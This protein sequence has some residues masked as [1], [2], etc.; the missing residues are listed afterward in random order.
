[1]A[2][3]SVTR[4]RNNFTAFLKKYS[5]STPSA[6]A[7]KSLGLN[8]T[9]QY[10]F[11]PKGADLN[12]ENINL[13]KNEFL[14]QDFESAVTGNGSISSPD[15]NSNGELPKFWCIQDGHRLLYKQGSGPFYQQPY[16]EVFAS[17]LLDKLGYP[18]VP[19]TLAMIQNTPYSVCETFVIPD[20]EFIPANDILM[21]RKKTNS[22]SNY[23]HFFKCLEIL[24]IGV[25]KDDINNMIVFDKI[26]NNID[27]HYGN[28]GYIRN[29]ETLDFIEF[30][31]VFDNGNSLWYDT[32]DQEIMVREQPAKPFRDTQDKQLKLVDGTSL[33]I[34]NISQAFIEKTVYD[35]FSPALEA[36][37]V[38]ENS[39][40]GIIKCI[41]YNI[42]G[43]KSLQNSNGII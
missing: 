33:P 36:E 34:T 23:Q 29:P 9:D 22:D 1:M 11:K 31:P 43:V 39:L 25:T 8:L 14:K 2:Y 6:A 27:R 21:A 32:V 28:F 16:N 19:Y 26:I 24:N 37:K 3:R 15:S 7:Y 38:T 20:T 10:W 40:K 35:V 42:Q 18:H 13:F 17:K 4:S 30:S 5:V 12:W 41:G